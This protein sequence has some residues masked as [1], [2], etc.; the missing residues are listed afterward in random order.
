M[1]RRLG[2]IDSIWSAHGQVH[3][4]P[5]EKIFSPFWCFDQVRGSYL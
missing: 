5:L 1:E 3:R 2:P 4:G